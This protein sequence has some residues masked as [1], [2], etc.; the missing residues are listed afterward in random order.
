MTSIIGRPTTPLVLTKEERDY[1]EQ[2]VRLEEAVSRSMFERCR[3]ILRCADGIASKMVAAELGVHEN[4]VG[5]WRRRFLQDRIEGL[6]DA[7]RSGRPRTIDDDQ[8]AAV[9]ERTLQSTPE[10]GTQWSIRSM[11]AA[12]GFSHT[13]IRRIWAAFGLQPHHAHPFQLSNDPLFVDKVCDIVGLYLAPPNR[14]LALSVDEKGRKRARNH[15]QSA[16]SMMPDMP[17][18]QLHSRRGETPLFAALDVISGFVIGNYY[19]RRRAAE[20]LDFLRQIDASVATDHDVHIIMDNHATHKIAAVRSWLARHP[21]YHV[22]FTPT[23]TSWFNQVEIWFAELNRKHLQHD[24]RTSTSELESDI[25]AF[26]ESHTK[27][28]K[29]YKWTKSAADIGSSPK[30]FRKKLDQSQYREI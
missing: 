10:D 12:T 26:I 15:G 21:R 17:E 23:P 30:I 1:L 28:L 8:I 2:Q 11:A 5:K 4:T 20:L 14:A 18:R 3:I 16:L 22:H 27:S 19:K 6:F 25:R 9:I 7:D 13:T 24:L 29:P